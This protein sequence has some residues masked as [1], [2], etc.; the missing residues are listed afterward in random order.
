MYKYHLYTKIPLTIKDFTIIFI[1]F[2]N[3]WFCCFF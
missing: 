2:V 1:H 3:V